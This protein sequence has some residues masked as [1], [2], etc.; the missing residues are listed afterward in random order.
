MTITIPLERLQKALAY[1]PHTGVV[2]WKEDRGGR[3]A[4]SIAG[5][6][7]PTGYRH[8]RVDGRMFQEHRVAWALHYGEWPSAN[9]DHV[10]GNPSDNRIE[11]LRCVMQAENNKNARRRKDNTSGVTG[12][13][14]YKASKKWGAKIHRDGSYV[15]LG[16]FESMEDAITARKQAEAK[17]GYHANH[18]RAA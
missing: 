16:L 15:F 18:G 2:T 8:V 12:V 13:L 9:I 5:S 14:W 4:G 7:K 6:L 17:L 11:N 1:D 3:P 10:N